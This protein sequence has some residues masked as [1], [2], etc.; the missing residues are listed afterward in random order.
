MSGAGCPEVSER[1]AVRPNESRWRQRAERVHE[2]P[3]GTS[4]LGERF[5]R[6]TLA[7]GLELLLVDRVHI[8][9]DTDERAQTHLVLGQGFLAIRDLSGRGS[10]DPVPA[11]KV[12][13]QIAD[14]P[15]LAF[16]R[17]HRALK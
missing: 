2:F 1:F 9:G 3:M 17:P 12:R 14:A 13:D 5:L 11:R 4:E 15:T 16:A 6:G 10:A 7:P 8:I